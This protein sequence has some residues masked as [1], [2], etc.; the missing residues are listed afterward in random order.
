MSGPAAERTVAAALRGRWILETRSW[1]GRGPGPFVP[2][3]VSRAHPACGC[4]VQGDATCRRVLV[5]AFTRALKVCG[6]QGQGSALT[7]LVS[8]TLGCTAPSAFKGAGAAMQAP[9]RRPHVRPKTLKPACA[10]F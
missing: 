4:C 7:I 5:N 10:G 9:Q 3:G 6:C 1:Q 8:S 2:H